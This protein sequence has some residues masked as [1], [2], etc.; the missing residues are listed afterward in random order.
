MTQPVKELPTR[1]GQ[2]TIFKGRAVKPGPDGAPHQFGRST[3]QNLEI[4]VAM[5]IP[6]LGGAIKTIPLSFSANAAPYSK[7]KLAALG[8][9]EQDIATL[10]GI[11]KNEVDVRA[12]VEHYDGKDRLKWEILSGMQQFTTSNPISGREFAANL[13]ALT[14]KSSSNGPG[15]EKPS[16]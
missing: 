6:E 15:Y 11:D 13:A 3:N 4:L 5:A 16:F 9:Q 8:V 2:F 14:G 12:F 7:E 1:V 10:A